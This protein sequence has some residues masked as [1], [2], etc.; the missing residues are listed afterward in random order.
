MATQRKVRGRDL[1]G[2][3]IAIMVTISVSNGLQ[4]RRSEDVF[5]GDDLPLAVNPF[6]MKAAFDEALGDV[7]GACLGDGV[8]HQIYLHTGRA[9]LDED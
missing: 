7:S 2:R 8:L 9:F 5:F 1:I 6:E 4:I 3:V